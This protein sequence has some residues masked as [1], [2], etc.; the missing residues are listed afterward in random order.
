MEGTV[1]GD[2]KNAAGVY[3]SVKN[4]YGRVLSSTK[5]LK[6]SACC[7]ANRPH[8]I[9]RDALAQCAP[10]PISSLALVSLLFIIFVALLCAGCRTRSRVAT[11]D[12][13]RRCPLALRDCTYSTWG[14]GRDAI[15]TLLRTWCPFS[16]SIGVLSSVACVR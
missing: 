2:Y 14:P 11:T 13:A 15:A 9:I 16:P 8:K 3:E 1:Q 4:Y 6:T 5:D 12:A 10:P 7:T